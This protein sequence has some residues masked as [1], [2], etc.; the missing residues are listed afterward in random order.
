MS[1]TYQVLTAQQRGQ[2]R[3]ERARALEADIY[4]AE[5]QFEDAQS[6]AER[7]SLAMEI[8]QLRRRLKPHLVAMGLLVP[9][10][11]GGPGDAHEGADRAAGNGV[12]AAG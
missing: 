11:E 9:E 12:P 3:L 10:G 2:L 1:H 4:R 6:D 7:E 8:E 5:L